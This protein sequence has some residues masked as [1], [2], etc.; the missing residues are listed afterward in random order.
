MKQILLVIAFAIAT[1][2]SYA[3]VKKIQLQAAGL[4]CSMCS[5]AVFK[6][7]SS[8]AFVKE[9]KADIKSSSYIIYL[10]DENIWDF[11]ALKKAVENA[12]FSVAQ[13]SANIIFN[14]SKIENDTH[15]K[16]TGKTFHFLN[17]KPQTLSGD[18][19]ITVLDK[20]FVTAK[21]FK[22]NNKFT[23]MKC[24]Q[25]G[26]MESCCTKPAGKVGERIYHVTLKS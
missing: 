18:Y 25:T 20:N 23:T 10:K 26:T 17:V 7:I 11:D 21:E 6:A 8:I 12:G 24:Y 13:L 22:A 15:L 9:V 3:Q 4:T 16:Y 14:N 2:L 5:K 19:T 1:T